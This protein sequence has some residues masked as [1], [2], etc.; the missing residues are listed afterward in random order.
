[1]FK[2]V[3]QYVKTYKQYQKHTAQRFDE[4]LH[5]TKGPNAP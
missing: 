3:K 1:M 5:P 2:D 4:E